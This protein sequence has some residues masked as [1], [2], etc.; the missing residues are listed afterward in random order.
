[1]TAPLTPPHQSSSNGP[2]QTPSK[3]GGPGGPGGPGAGGPVESQGEYDRRSDLRRAAVV[4]VLVTLGGIGLGLLWVWLAP[5]VPLISDGTA[6][7]LSDSEGE[8][9]IGADGTFVL[10]ALAFGALSAALVFWFQRRGGI[11]LVVGLAL[12]GLFGSLVAWRLGVWLGPS[13]DVVAHARAVGRGV[14]FDAPLRLR[15][16][17]AALLVWSIGAMAVHLGLTALFGPRDPEPEWGAYPG[18]ST[19]GP[20]P[21]AGPGPGV[22]PGGSGAGGGVPP[23][24]V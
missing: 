21:G 18:W 19:G 5:R 24:G 10:L 22:V 17:G 12:G 4:T 11:A 6:V 20:V 1:M 15:A 2:W 14:V 16:K 13:Q 7:F 23:A 8:E 9:A 3:W